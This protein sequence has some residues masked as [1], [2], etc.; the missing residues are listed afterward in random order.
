MI[1]DRLKTLNQTDIYSMVL[2]ALYKIKDVPEYSTVSEL[3]YVLDRTNLLNLC[4]YFG[5]LTIKVPTISEIEE[6]M[7]VLLIYQK[8]NIE[9]QN[10]EEIIQGLDSAN[11]RNIR[12][13]YNKLCEVLSKY[14]FNPR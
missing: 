6:L 2:F 9:H 13:K 1:K 8:V 7:G 10:L 11:S 12:D 14:E 4:E 3:A 5:G